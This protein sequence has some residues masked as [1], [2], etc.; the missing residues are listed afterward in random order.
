MQSFDTQGDFK[1][2]YK[3]LIGGIV[4]RPIAVV[5]T[6]NSNGTNNLAPFSF[7]TAVSAAPMIIAFC[8]LIRSSDGEQKDTVK[9]ILREKEFVVNFAVEKF[10]NE[11]NKTSTELTYG[12]DEFQFAGLTAIDSEKVKAKRLLESPLQFECIF[13]DRISYGEKPGAGQIITGEVVRVHVDENILTDGKID[14]KKFKAVAR[15]G[16]NDWFRQ[17]D[18]FELERLMKTQI[19]K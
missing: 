16:G 9:N 13:R 7:F 14:I 10:V 8:P 12:E 18:I 3:W 2:N 6:R 15:G 5:S 4:P 19:Q 11:I 17:T 1:N